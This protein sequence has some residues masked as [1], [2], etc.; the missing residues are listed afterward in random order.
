M[1]GNDSLNR[2]HFRGVRVS[3]QPLKS[4]HSFPVA[5]CKSLRNTD[6][7]SFDVLGVTISPLW[8][9]RVAAI[10]SKGH[11]PCGRHWL[12]FVQSFYKLSCDER[13]IGSLLPFGI[14]DGFPVS[15]PILHIT[16]G[17]SLSSIS[18]TTSRIG[19]LCRSL[20]GKDPP[21]EKWLTVLPVENTNGE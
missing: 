9:G 10:G 1:I 5:F 17:I 19:S 16:C 13:P 7:K 3:Q 15:R 8:G 11:Q 21:G 20:S 4:F 14:G 12:T 18:F 6:L 2:N